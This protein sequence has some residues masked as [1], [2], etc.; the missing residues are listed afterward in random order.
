[1][2]AYESQAIANIDATKA[3]IET[4]KGLGCAFALDDFGSGFSPL[5]VI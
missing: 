3:F 5:M 2:I 1:M 4:F